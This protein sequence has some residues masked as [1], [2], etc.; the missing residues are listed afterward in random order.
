[1]SD[2]TS[3]QTDVA[4]VVHQGELLIDEGR[5]STAEEAEVRVQMSLLNQRWEDL[6]TK[7]TDRQTT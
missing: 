4:A 2:L 1:M 7:A 6:R 3:H 5:L